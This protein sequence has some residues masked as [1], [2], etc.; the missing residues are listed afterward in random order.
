MSFL[1]FP[2]SQIIDTHN[3][4]CIYTW[5]YI[6]CSLYLSVWLNREI[7]HENIDLID[8][9]I[10]K[11]KINNNSQDGIPI[12]LEVKNNKKANKNKKKN[13]NSNNIKDKIRSIYEYIYCIVK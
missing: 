9:N 10:I 4:S 6:Q 7:T 3:L 2:Y 8:Y 5:F 12:L 1:N 13:Y 11:E